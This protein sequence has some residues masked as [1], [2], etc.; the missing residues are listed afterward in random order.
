MRLFTFALA[1]LLLLPLAACGGGGGGSSKQFVVQNTGNAVAGS[2]PTAFSGRVFAY[3]ASE[4]STGASGTDLNGDSDQDD[5]VAVVF[6]MDTGTE[7]V[8]GIAVV[9]FEWLGEENLYLVVDES[10]DSIDW[11]SDGDTSADDLSLVLYKRSDG[12]KT[13]L[14]SLS[15]ATGPCLG[16]FGSS[17]FFTEELA[18]MPGP[19]MT[20]L[21]R[22]ELVA[23]S[24]VVPVMTSSD[25]PNGLS[26]NL[27]GTRQ[28]LIFGYV[29]EVTDAADL[30]SDGDASDTHVLVLLDSTATGTLLHLTGLGLS[31]ADAVYD[32]QA[33]ASGDWLVAVLVSEAAHEDTLAPQS[34]V[35]TGFNDPNLFG[36][37]WQPPQCDPLADVDTLDQVLFWIDFA[38]FVTDPIGSP[39]VNTGLVGT[40][41]VLALQNHVATDSLEADDGGCDLNQDGDTDD[42]V[43]RLVETSTPVLP[44]NDP[45]LDIV[46][47]AL[48]ADV[49]G[50]TS[51]MA[52]VGDRL[53]ILVDEALDS[54]DYDQKMDG[55]NPVD[56]GLLGWRHPDTSTSWRF[57]H[58]AD[59]NGTFVNFFAGATWMAETANRERLSVAVPE[60]IEGEDLNFEPGGGD[61]D[62]DDSFAAFAF[63]NTQ[64]RL[65]FPF[66]RFGVDKDNAGIVISGDIAYY[67]VSEAADRRDWN[68][69][70]DSLDFVLYRSNLLNG[71][72]RY[73]GTANNL[74]RPVIEV[75]PND[76][77]PYGAAF[78]ASEASEGI[79]FNLDGDTSDF[80]WRWFRL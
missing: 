27:I 40:S 33:R 65:V 29:S 67:R 36:D 18:V 60:A 68:G 5:S 61:G 72:T 59:I 9:A 30:N 56:N 32:A 21:R 28:G 13:F 74:D 35:Y 6:E 76:T 37:T 19:G 16:V 69:D 22:I 78:L 12:S 79:D 24:T 53:V 15:D 43:V 71:D 47:L 7:T 50:G 70:G 63:F 14:A 1:P 17:L 34:G 48:A 46:A 3:M 8:V 26:P 25:A 4:A 11:D 39:P 55:G 49:P 57:N 38:D 10:K 20:T 45:D 64:P 58:G 66:V 2:N 54:T 73:M 31:G 62:L 75:S 41:R 44:E 80:V 42:R 51:G 52:V 77:L 23:A